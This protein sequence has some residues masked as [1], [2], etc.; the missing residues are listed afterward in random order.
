MRPATQSRKELGGVFILPFWSR[1]RFLHKE[2]RGG[3]MDDREAM[4]QLAIPGEVCE[5]RMEGWSMWKH[6]RRVVRILFII[7][8]R[9]GDLS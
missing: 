5:G 7:A 4:G 6:G 2:G 3:G 8:V 9:G 1:S